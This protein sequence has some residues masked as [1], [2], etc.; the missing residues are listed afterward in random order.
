M[1][2]HQKPRRHASRV[3]LSHASSTFSVLARSA[4]SRTRFVNGGGGIR[5]HGPPNGGQRF[6]RPRR[7]GRNAALQLESASRGNAGGNESRPPRLCDPSATERD[8][9]AR[10]GSGTLGRQ[11]GITA[12][13][14]V[15]Q[16]RDRES[17]V[18]RHDPVNVTD[19]AWAARRQCQRCRIVRA[20]FVSR[21]GRRSGRRNG[22][23]CFA[24]R[25]V[26]VALGGR[27]VGTGSTQASPS[28]G[29]LAEDAGGL[30]AEG[31][32]SRGRSGS[33]RLAVSS[34]CPPRRWRVSRPGDARVAAPGCRF[35]R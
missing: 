7:P 2:E 30:S 11:S 29:L 25:G 3:L 10:I 28:P 12:D 8:S 9:A 14:R 18:F 22:E 24:T 31:A 27:P 21:P 16:P 23:A 6:S 20:A 5:T 35:C 32:V 33:G 1:D 19:G 13:A 17:R 15:P 4:K 34:G 26:A